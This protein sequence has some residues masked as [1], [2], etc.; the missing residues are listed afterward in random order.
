MLASLEDWHSLTDIHALL[1]FTGDI[2]KIK[3]EVLPAVGADT[4]DL[5]I[6]HHLPYPTQEGIEKHLNIE[7]ITIY[8][9]EA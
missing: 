2:I 8:N 9:V 4:G 1:L 6:L 3:L 5:V 7:S